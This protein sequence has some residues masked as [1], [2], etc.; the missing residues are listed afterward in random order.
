MS[1]SKCASFLK[2]PISSLVFAKPY[3]LFSSNLNILEKPF[4][5]TLILLLIILLWSLSIKSVVST[6]LGKIKTTFDFIYSMSPLKV[7]AEV[8]HL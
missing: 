1:I 4:V 5:F 6:S 3:W 7:L 8:R 2:T